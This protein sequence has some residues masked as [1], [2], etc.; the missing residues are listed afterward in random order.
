MKRLISAFIFLGFKKKKKK[1][2]INNR[3]KETSN[4]GNILEESGGDIG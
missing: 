3:N 1:R 4:K 2:E